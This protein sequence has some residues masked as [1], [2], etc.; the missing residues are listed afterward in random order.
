MQSILT[1]MNDGLHVHFQHAVS[2]I[3]PGQ[4][5]VIYE[6]DDIVAG[7]IIHKDLM[8]APLTKMTAATSLT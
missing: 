7:G 6:D 5:A 2:S 8:Y 4:S 3:A 1:P